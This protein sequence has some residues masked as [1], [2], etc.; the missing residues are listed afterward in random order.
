MWE[1]PAYRPWTQGRCSFLGHAPPVAVPAA[2]ERSD[3]R[4]GED[5]RLAGWRHAPGRCASVMRTTSRSS[6][7]KTWTGTRDGTGRTA[8]AG[9]HM[10]RRMG[11]ARRE[12]GE[13]VPGS[14][15]WAAFSG[16]TPSAG[17]RGGSSG[18]RSAEAAGCDI[19]G[20]DGGDGGARCDVGRRLAASNS[21]T[22]ELAC[23]GRE[24]DGGGTDGKGAGGATGG[25]RAAGAVRHA[26]IACRGR[27]RV[28]GTGL[29]YSSNPSPTSAPALARSV[30]RLDT[31]SRSRRCR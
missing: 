4:R 8:N 5:R 11:L 21:R 14:G 29:P 1:D 20:I 27:G 13:D 30:T 10:A 24:G 22:N 17:G 15:L 18:E 6:R 23:A 31:R 2:R 9:G 19:S 7:L 3:R 28:R 25:G 16:R 12:P 26:G